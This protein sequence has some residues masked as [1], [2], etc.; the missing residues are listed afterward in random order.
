MTLAEVLSTW[1]LASIPLSFAVG[2]LL[3]GRIGS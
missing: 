2:R 1:V 3:R